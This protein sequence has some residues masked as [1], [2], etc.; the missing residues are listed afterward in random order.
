MDRYITKDLLLVVIN[1]QYEVLYASS[2]ISRQLGFSE[3][4]IVGKSLL[5][6]IDPIDK[7]LFSSVL[8]FDSYDTQ[9]IEYLQMRCSDG[10]FVAYSAVFQRIMH[11]N[12][13]EELMLAVLKNKLLCSA[14]QP[15]ITS[16]VFQAINQSEE[17]FALIS[18]EGKILYANYTFLKWYG[19]TESEIKALYFYDIDD[20]INNPE[21]WIQLVSHIST[22][23][24]SKTDTTFIT[25]AGIKIET[26][27]CWQVYPGDTNKSFIIKMSPIKERKENEKKIHKTLE[28]QHILSQIAFIL[29]THENFE[30]KINES[31]RILGNFLH[32]SRIV[33]FQNILSNKAAS[34]T[35]EWHLE[36]FLPQRYELQAIPYSLLPELTNHFSKRECVHYEGLANMP[37]E[38]LPYFNP[39]QAQ[40]FMAVPL[41]LDKNSPFGFICFIDHNDKHNWKESDKRFISTFCE[42]LTS[43]FRQKLNIDLLVK[44][45][46]RFRELAE[47]LP[48]MICEAAIN[49]KVIFANKY[50][51]VQFGFTEN[52]LN[53]GII[54]FNFFHSSCR[55]RVLDN[56]ERLLS[57]ENIKTE[58]Y[59][60]VN[61]E[62]VEIPVLLYMNII[63]Q[64]QLPVG[65]R[66][67]IVDITER[68]VQ[69][70]HSERL[71][72]VVETLP[73]ALIESDMDNNFDFIN[74]RAAQLK[75]FFLDKV[76]E[77]A[78][79]IRKVFESK[80]SIEH[81]LLINS[82]ECKILYMF[83]DITKKVNLFLYG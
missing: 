25:A 16:I 61:R 23:H 13:S 57:G 53:K 8:S 31:L 72:A 69:E 43:T 4:E 76:H 12:S 20:E 3:K 79:N 52:D 21:K 29:N 15:D 18:V 33:I 39:K 42:I 68:K 24:Y 32:I 80:N 36:E 54:F 2:S 34:C 5:N 65:L 48:E 1:K 28:R 71:A 83:N 63:M 40:T 19:L 67:V 6:Y 55:Q 45:E 62:K 10:S 50:T 38:I 51:Q 58:E 59:V 27:R 41:W 70:K 26:E 35:F 14:D 75:P 44:S 9:R 66:A 37:D 47:L 49:G 78:Q 73:V 77:I 60:I 82:K 17:A 30:Y 56:F 46:R 7:T 74:E 81:S 22:T 11:D 64:D